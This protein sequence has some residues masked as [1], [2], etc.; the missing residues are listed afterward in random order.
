MVD[1]DV[2]YFEGNLNLQPVLKPILIV[3]GSSLAVLVVAIWGAGRFYEMRLFN[4]VALKTNL[5][6]SEGFVG[7]E[8]QHI[9]YSYTEFF[10]INKITYI[11]IRCIRTWEIIQPKL[12]CN[13]WTL[14]PSIQSL[15]NT[16]NTPRDYTLL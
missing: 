8:K 13:T 3:C 1:N 6:E 15:I 14:I 11:I 7:V 2:L 10:G 16:M 12:M 5:D 9:L 4:K